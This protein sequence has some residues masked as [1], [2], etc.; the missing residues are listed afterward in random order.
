MRT[1]LYPAISLFL[2][3][4]VL[5]SCS[6]DEDKSPEY[7]LT[8]DGVEKNIGYVRYNVYDFTSGAR[9]GFRFSTASSPE[10]FDPETDFDLYL[11]LKTEYMGIR[12]VQADRAHRID[13]KSKG[14]YCSTESGVQISDGS[15]IIKLGSN[16]QAEIS[17][18]MVIRYKKTPVSEYTYHRIKCSFKGKMQHAENFGGI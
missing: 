8:V 17:I 7:T 18:S 11:E 9:G 6:K 12:G 4:T 1:I 15:I 14:E 5:V 2:I 10:T 13:L 16:D 3:L